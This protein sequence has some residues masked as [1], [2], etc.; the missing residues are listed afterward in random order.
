MRTPRLQ[1]PQAG[2]KAGLAA[3]RQCERVRIDRGAVDLAGGDE[4]DRLEVRAGSVIQTYPGE[5]RN[6]MSASPEL[7]G[8]TSPRGGAEDRVSNRSDVARPVASA[9]R[10]ATATKRPSG[11]LGAR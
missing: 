5:Q 9:I 10:V 3:P 7:N 8:S 1:Y 2:R 6:P 4:P 11:R